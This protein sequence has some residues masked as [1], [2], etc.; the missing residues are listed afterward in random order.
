MHCDYLRR[1]SRLRALISCRY[2]SSKREMNSLAGAG[3]IPPGGSGSA[4]MASNRS[5]G[6]APGRR[7]V[8][9]SGMSKWVSG[10]VVLLVTVSLVPSWP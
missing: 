4:R 1:P 6:G 7:I 9:R 5:A 3:A 2:A 10:R 8:R